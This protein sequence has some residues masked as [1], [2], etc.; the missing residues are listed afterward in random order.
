MRRRPATSARSVVH[1]HE[2]AIRRVLGDHDYRLLVRYLSGSVR[3]IQKLETAT[4]PLPARPGVK[5]RLKMS[6]LLSEDARRAI[7]ALA[8][9]LAAGASQDV[10]LPAATKHSIKLVK[11]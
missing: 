7:E 2:D 4:V 3:I 11:K 6:P 5:R 1:A 8:E 9:Q 10:S